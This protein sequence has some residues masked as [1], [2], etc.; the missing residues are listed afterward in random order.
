[1]AIGRPEAAAVKATAVETLIEAEPSPP[2]PQLS[3]NR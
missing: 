1:L 3:A 2:V